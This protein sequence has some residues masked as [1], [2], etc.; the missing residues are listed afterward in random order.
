MEIE[1]VIS[2]NSEKKRKN[3]VQSRRLTPDYPEPVTPAHKRLSLSGIFN[4]HY[5]FTQK[6]CNFQIYQELAVTW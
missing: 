2:L 6:I 3:E 4:E 1:L 5:R